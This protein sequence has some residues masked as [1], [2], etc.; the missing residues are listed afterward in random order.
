MT[1]DVTE[2]FRVV[3]LAGVLC[4]GALGA[5]IARQRRFDFVGFTVLGVV[6]GLAGGV[7]R[8]VMLQVGQPV[9]LTDPAYLITAMIGVLAAQL[10]RMEGRR[11]RW[12]M[13]GADA[14]ALG[15]WA[16]TGTIKAQIVGLG[17]LPSLF[18]GVVTAVGGGMVRDICIGQVPAVLGGNTLYATAAATASA[19]IL[20]TP[21]QVRSTWGMGLGIAI[22]GGLSLIARWRQWRL[23]VDAD[24]HLSAD[25][26]RA[27][28]RRSE[29]AGAKAEKK[30]AAGKGRGV[31]PPDRR[32]AR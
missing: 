27:L 17:W 9:A 14:L 18:L 6:S 16:A 11:W 7:L 2:A 23:P 28:I 30:R 12:P 31:R 20:L 3:D 21:V 15:A 29:R 25:Q 24:V 19:A 10:I 4:N 22:G 26:L 5:T 13:I 32:A 1:V 8:D